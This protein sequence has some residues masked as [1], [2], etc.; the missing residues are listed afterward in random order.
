MR[1]VTGNRGLVGT[2]TGLLGRSGSTIGG[3]WAKAAA[4]E[5]ERL[6]KT[7]F[8]LKN[9]LRVQKIMAQKCIRRQRIRMEVRVYEE[10]RACLFQHA[11]SVCVPRNLHGRVVYENCHRVCTFARLRVVGKTDKNKKTNNLIDDDAAHV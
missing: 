1:N 10:A 7:F 4:K 3:R 8:A 6:D 11:R 2:V 9:D 5:L